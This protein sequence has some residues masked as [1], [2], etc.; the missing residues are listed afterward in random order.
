MQDCNVTLRAGEI[1][2]IAGGNGLE[3]IDPAITT[4]TVGIDINAEYLEVV[5]QRHPNLHALE[6]HHHDLAAHGSHRRIGPEVPRAESGRVDDE[7][8][9]VVRQQADHVAAQLARDRPPD[10]RGAVQQ[11]LL[12]ELVPVLRLREVEAAA[13]Q[14]AADLVALRLLR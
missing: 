5:A 2:G 13:E 1:L 12:H 6:L 4:R 9:Q 3:H 10:V 14:R 8:A 7:A 11:D